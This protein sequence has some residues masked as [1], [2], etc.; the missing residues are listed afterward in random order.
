LFLRFARRRTAD[1]DRH[2]ASAFFRA[3]RKSF[4]AKNKNRLDTRNVQP[5]F[6]NRKPSVSGVLP[7]RAHTGVL[8]IIA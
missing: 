7:E 6:F 8:Q 1:A 5:V 2:A 3:L 4:R